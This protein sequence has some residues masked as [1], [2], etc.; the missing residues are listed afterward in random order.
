M[1]AKVGQVQTA[2]FQLLLECGSRPNVEAGVYGLKHL[3]KQIF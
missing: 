1:N 2:P 3:S